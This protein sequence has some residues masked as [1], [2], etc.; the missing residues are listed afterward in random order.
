MLRFT[1]LTST[2][3]LTL[4]SL[5]QAI[6]TLAFS[7]SDVSLTSTNRFGLSEYSNVMLA[8]NYA[9]DN[10]SIGISYQVAPLGGL[11]IQKA[12]IG[13]AKK[14]MPNLSAGI[15]LNYEHF[16]S[17]DAFYQARGAFTFNA[18]VY[19]QINEKLNVG[20]QTYNPTR[21]RILETPLERLPSRVRLGIDYKL[22]EAIT[23]YSDVS[24][25]SEQNLDLNAG[26]ELIR[27]N[28]VIRGGFGLNQLIA[29]GFG[30]KKNKIQVDVTAAYHNQ[31][32]ISPALNIG[33][34][35]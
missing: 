27:N 12:Q 30:W 26:L 16:S 29:M 14:L 23:L 7:P 22:A 25:T 34:A 19:Y 17:I 15:A 33:Y 4:C 3:A 6:A 9:L 11:T 21:S 18:G 5:A 32:G 35:F 31:L 28:Y 13:F 1:T 8:G 10:S 2:L 20:F 24:Q